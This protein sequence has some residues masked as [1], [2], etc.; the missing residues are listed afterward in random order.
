M[1]DLEPDKSRKIKWTRITEDTLK[2]FSSRLCL[3]SRLGQ[4]VPI[5]LSL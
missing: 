3:F 4:M 2:V 5:N 1:K